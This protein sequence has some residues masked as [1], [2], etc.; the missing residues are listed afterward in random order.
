MIPDHPEKEINFLDQ[1]N[2]K[3]ELLGITWDHPRGYE[4]LMAVSEEYTKLNPNI[5]VKWNIRTLKEFG[6]MP[7]EDLI[8]KYDLITIDHP[9]MGQADKNK[10]LFPIENYLSENELAGHASQSVGRSF[11]SYRYNN[12]L[13]ALPI[14]AAALVSAY[15]KDLF[16]KIGLEIPKTREDLIQIYK[17]IPKEFSIAWP[18]CSVDLWCTFLTL[19]AQDA[20][21]D[22]ISNYQINE[23]VGSAVIDEL[24]VHLE[25][26][27]LDSINMNPIKVL[28][29]MSKDDEIIYSPFL[30]G[31]TNYSRVGYKKNIVHFTDCPVNPSNN[32]SSILGGV[33]LGVSSNSKNVDAAVSFT[34]YC[35]SPS[36]QE[37][38]FTQDGGQP[39]NMIAWE[40]ED[41]NKLCNNFFKN[42]IKTLQ[43]AY[44]RPQHPLWNQFQEQG[45]ELLHACLLKNE[46]SE[47]MMKDLN[48]LYQSVIPN[49]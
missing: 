5:N 23:K 33:G 20:G 37:T 24:K 48:Q 18:L 19:C 44:V 21:R 30:F 46:S 35:A 43:T 13:Y 47:K 36:V 1:K 45:S 22:F 39:G 42:T 3:I 26:L 27:H 28:D 38:T 14:D 34:K 9:Y 49:G 25:F 31:Y 12:H 15:R 8:G 11:Q 2:N 41:N 4:P 7:I 29:R 10:L 16:D 40:S 6:D 32:I 17:N